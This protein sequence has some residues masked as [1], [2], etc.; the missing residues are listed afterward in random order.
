[1]KHKSAVVS[2]RTICPECEDG[3]YTLFHIKGSKWECECGYAGDVP[4]NEVK[5]AKE[6]S[7]GHTKRVG[8]KKDAARKN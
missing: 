3:D 1:M 7:N 8:R 5:V 4:K 6:K 2:V